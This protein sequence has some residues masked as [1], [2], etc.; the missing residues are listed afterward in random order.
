MDVLSL[1]GGA[2]SA[3]V[4]TQHELQMLTKRLSSGLRITAASEDPS[5]LAIAESLAS[6]VSGLDEGVRQI[7]NANNALTVAEGAMATI[8][9]ILQRMRSLVVQ[10]RSDLQSAGDTLNIQAELTQLRL[11]I[12]RI[13]DN[14]TFNGR[15][16]LDGSASSALPRAP[17]AMLVVNPNASGGGTII[18]Q[19]VDP[20]MPA[21]APNAPQLV[22][23]LSVDSYDPIANALNL[24]VTIGS[25]EKPFGADQTSGVQIGNGTNAQPG[26]PS[27]TPGAPSFYQYDQYGTYVMSFN[28]GTLTPADVGKTALIVTLPGQSKAP[29]GALSVNSGDAEGST[30]SVDIAAMSSVNLGVNEVI[31]GTDLQ[32]QGAEYRIDYA[33]QTV[34]ASRA[35]LGAQMVA[36]QAAADNGSTTSVNTQASESA[37]RDLNVG[38]A[39]VDFTR[40]QLL[41]QFQ[42]R[43]V[44]DADKLSHNV[45]TLVADS[46]I[47]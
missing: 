10:A 21:V 15:Q 1:T 26:F 19:S 32:N 25:Q 12:D 6:K 17:R 3:S 38:S 8:G 5:G 39:M 31:L 22:Q 47:Q 14:T 20:S 23:Y 41:V 29:G 42:T 30:I 28:V 43:I 46:I 2:L 40:A 37:I 7:Q 33:V 35:T 34:A 13:A 27:P 11:E 44:A 4:R 18:D 45:A 36:L 16:L 24:T 9:S